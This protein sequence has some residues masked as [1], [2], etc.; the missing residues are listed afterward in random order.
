MVL[1]EC[2]YNMYGICVIRY[3]VDGILTFENLRKLLTQ[4]KLHIFLIFQC[5]RLGSGGPGDRGPMHIWKLLE[6]GAA[7]RGEPMAMEDPIER[8]SVGG[9]WHHIR[10]GVVCCICW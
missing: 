10:G 5:Q 8:C 4:Q 3:T 6:S 7:D 1:G 9:I 2:F